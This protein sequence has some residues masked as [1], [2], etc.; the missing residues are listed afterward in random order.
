[1]FM[2]SRRF[3]TFRTALVLQAAPR[4]F[5]F[6]TC[7]IAL[8]V[9]VE[10]F[11]IAMLS[12]DSEQ[13]PVGLMV[14]DARPKTPVHPTP[15]DVAAQLAILPAPQ[16][17]KIEMPVVQPDEAAYFGGRP[18]RKTKTLRMLV[19]AYSPD[20]RSCAPFA[21]NITASGYSVWT[22]GMKLVA[23]DTKLLPFKSIITVPGY[24]GG[25]P[26]PVLDRGGR[27]KGERLDVLYPTHAIAR[28]WGKKW[29]DV[30]VWE[31]AD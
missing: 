27:I 3:S 22:N 5:L 21:D 23:A 26:V 31:Y 18:L 25:R 1:M 10:L 30:D 13:P 8:L 9:A 14:I 6:A 19:T 16:P 15:K 7:A 2:P 4:A 12:N 29:L 28:R 11:A 17:T 24:H 20:E